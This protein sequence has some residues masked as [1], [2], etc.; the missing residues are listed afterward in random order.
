ML[1]ETGDLTARELAEEVGLTP[2]PVWRRVQNLEKAGVITG[3]VALVDPAALNLDVTALVH[4]RTN[5]H[6]AAWLDR[7][8]AGIAD[9]P[10]IV[11]AYR[12]SGE[13]DYTL[14]V[15]VPSI[16]AYDDFYKRLIARVHLY[17]VRTVFVMEQMKQTTALPLDYL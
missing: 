11:E 2:T 12:T 13:I 9:L 16:E 10:E 7:F 4:I 15:V 6:S 17:D 5:D 8:C 3:R 14:K 1:Q